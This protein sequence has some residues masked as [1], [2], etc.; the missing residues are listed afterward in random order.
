VII[1]FGAQWCGPCKR[2]DMNYLLSLSTQIKWYEC[3]LDQNDYTP[4][5]CGVRTIPAFLAIVNGVPQP[6]LMSSDTNRIAEWMKSGFK[7]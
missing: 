4:G 2:V 1:K 6:V 3:D 5:Y 7:Q